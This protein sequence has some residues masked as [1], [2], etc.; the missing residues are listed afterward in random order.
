M[1]SSSKLSSTQPIDGECCYRN[2]IYL[3]S[4]I[5]RVSELVPSVNEALET[6]NTSKAI[7][8]VLGGIKLLKN[9][10]LKADLKLN[11]SLTTLVLNKP[12]LFSNTSAVIEVSKT[13]PDP[14]I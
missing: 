1:T 7:R 6:K 4:N 2:T 3:S 5:V 13:P 10:R 11:E 8:F 12:E 9:A 14:I